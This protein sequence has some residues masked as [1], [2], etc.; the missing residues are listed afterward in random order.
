MSSEV[1]IRARG[2]G[3]RYAVF[4]RPADRLKQMLVRGR[5]KYYRDFWALSEADFEIHRGETVG[6]VGRNGSGKSTLLQMVCGTLTPT[7]GELTVRGRVAALLELGAGFNPEFTGRENVFVNG[8]ILGLDKAEI[9][10]R[11]DSIAAFADIGEFIDQPVKTYSSGM[12]V[13]LAFA[14][15][16]NMEPEILVIDEILAVGDERFQRKCFARIEAI[17]DAGAAILFVSHSAQTVLQLCDRAILLERGR[18]VLSGSPAI[19][20]RSYQRLLYAPQARYDEVL[21]EISDSDREEHQ[22]KNG[23]HGQDLHNPGGEIPKG[24][25]DRSS[26]TP[27]ED[28]YFDPGLV[29]ESTTSYPKSGASISNL[30]MTDVESRRV[31]VLGRTQRFDLS[32]EVD[33]AK[34]VR[35]VRF[36]VHIRTPTGLEVTGQRFPE[37][38][39]SLHMVKAGTRFRL[40]FQF[41]TRLLPGVY[42]VGGGVWNED[43]PQCLHRV[44]DGLMF[45]VVG[46]HGNS[47]FGLFDG[48]SLRPQCIV[49]DGDGDSSSDR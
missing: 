23:G 25:A 39:R 26:D 41:D 20:I 38:G 32:Y 12:F 21:A 37:L 24:V 40:V 49:L 7:C 19:V 44:I 6:I 46:E 18:R 47:S 14:V 35:G 2:L 48:V 31:N 13:R 42:F 30:Q 11:F 27:Q 29:P 8:S 10:R 22:G 5:R 43:E 33:F 9:E 34:G 3:K 36:G 17:R 1:A 4:D 28:A 45:R 16:I 15:A